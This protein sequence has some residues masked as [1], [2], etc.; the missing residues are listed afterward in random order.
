M[1]KILLYSLLVVVVSSFTSCM[2]SKI[3]YY[4]GT[5]D[6]DTPGVKKFSY[7]EEYDNGVGGT[8]ATF[9]DVVEIPGKDG[10]RNDSVYIVTEF[11]SYSPYKEN[12][13]SP[14][15]NV[16]FKNTTKIHIDFAKT[17]MYVNGTPYNISGTSSMDG[18]KDIIVTNY[19]AHYYEDKAYFT[20]SELNLSEQYKQYT[21]QQYDS[22]EYNEWKYPVITFNKD[23]SPLKMEFEFVFNTSNSKEEYR[24]KMNLYQ[25]NLFKLKDIS[26]EWDG[27]SSFPLKDTAFYQKEI[28]R[29]K[30]SW[31]KIGKGIGSIRYLPLLIVY[32]FFILFG[33]STQ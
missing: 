2:V 16:K 33:G 24:Y 17:R 7:R 11:L 9:S 18:N 15:L 28:T 12:Y 20:L 29:K 6:S 25:T 14:Y 4:F 8:I 22:V 13:H 32:P 5:L 23:N 1:K 19:P 30:I 10:K 27:W 26:N 31:R 3:D 21:T